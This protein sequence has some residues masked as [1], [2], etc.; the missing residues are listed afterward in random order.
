MSP[1]VPP[2]PLP[3]PK[4]TYGPDLAVYQATPV[5]P[6]CDSED[7]K[8]KYHDPIWDRDKQALVVTAVFDFRGCSTLSQDHLHNTCGCCGYQWMTYC[9]D[10]DPDEEPTPVPDLNRKAQR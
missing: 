10:H 2:P 1:V 9:A 8:Q 6:K 7:V 4:K 5:C 3:A